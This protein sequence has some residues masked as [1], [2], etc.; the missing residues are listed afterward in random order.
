MRGRRLRAVGRA[1]GVRSGLCGCEACWGGVHPAQS[2][3]WPLI[4]FG[5]CAGPGLMTTGLP[6]EMDGG[7]GMNMRV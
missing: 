5:L 1:D 6:I 7:C 4:G 2:V 3:W